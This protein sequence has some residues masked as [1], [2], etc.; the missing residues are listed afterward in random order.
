MAGRVNSVRSKVC[1]LALFPGLILGLTAAREPGAADKLVEV[2]HF[3]SELLAREIFRRTNEVRLEQGVAP[4]KVD[5]RL[6]AAAAG[7]AAMLALRFHSGHDNP[8]RNHGDPS[9][10]VAEA[11]L[12]PGTVAENAATVAARNQV[13]S[14]GYTYPEQAAVIVADWMRSPGHRA[15]LLSPEFHYLGCAARAAFSPGN[16]PTVYAIQVFYRPVPPSPPPNSALQPGATRIK[17]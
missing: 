10:R 16:C 17:R 8:L 9:A 4:L 15:N 5:S 13:A 14:R 2:Q 6:A 12:P 3:D 7:Q 11:G 1:R